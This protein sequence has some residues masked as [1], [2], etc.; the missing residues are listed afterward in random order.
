MYN[1]QCYFG[2]AKMCFLCFFDQPLQQ[3]YTRRKEVL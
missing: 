1:G 2:V 3:Y